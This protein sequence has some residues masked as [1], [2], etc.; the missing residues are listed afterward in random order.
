MS[1][2]L[3]W[4]FHFEDTCFPL[5]LWKALES[6][7]FSRPLFALSSLSG[8]PISQSSF[9]TTFCLSLIIKKK[10]THSF[11]FYYERIP[12]VYSLPNWI[13]RI[14][15]GNKRHIQKGNWRQ[16]N[17]GTKYLQRYSQCGRTSK[18]WDIPT[19]QQQCKATAVPEPD[20]AG[21]GS[22]VVGL[23]RAVAHKAGSSDKSCGDRGKKQWLPQQ[24][25]D[26]VGYRQLILII[27]NTY[28]L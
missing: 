12:W 10:N 20:R 7:I 19:D 17:E 26:K 11:L 25:R 24:S 14:L 27:H 5:I 28:V 15:S 18:G 6:M 9:Y 23:W 2:L 3:C 4:V 8:T 22:E 13:T 1:Y 21:K 16:F